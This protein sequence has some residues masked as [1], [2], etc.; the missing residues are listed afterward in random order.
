MKSYAVYNNKG[1]VG[2]STITLLLLDIF[3]SIKVG[4]IRQARVLV[5]D[6]D[7]QSS[8]S[9]SLL[10]NKQVQELKNKNLTFCNNLLESLKSKKSVDFSPYIAKKEATKSTKKRLKLG[11]ID[12]M[13]V[14]KD[15]LIEF[16]KKCSTENSIKIAKY[17]RQNF[18]KNYDFVFFDLPANIDHRNKLSMLAM[19]TSD[20]IL[21]PTEPTKITINAL[22]DTIEN[23][24]YAQNLMINEELKTMKNAIVLNKT[25]RRTK[26]YKLHN[27]EIANIARDNDMVIF[28]S[29]LPSA[30]TLA[31][32][33]DETLCFETL[34]EKYLTYYDKSKKVAL[35]LIKH[36]NLTIKTK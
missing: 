21:I 34:K 27:Q 28:D 29:F 20:M 5:V 2:K 32:S 36:S 30:P 1:G 19:Q 17:L 4:D 13:C 23:I 3:S 10:G 22:N 24:K 26:Q 31:S 11:A 18:S 16:E 7:A 15:S 25:D 35:E 14:K 12:V 6:V 9:I 33:T 8:S